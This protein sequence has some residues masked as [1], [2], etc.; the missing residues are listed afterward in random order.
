MSLARP[1]TADFTP[2]SY[3]SAD[4]ANYFATAKPAYPYYTTHNDPMAKNTSNPAGIYNRAG[5][6]YPDVSAVGDNVVIFTGGAPTL[7]G[8]TSAS[9][10]AFA[11]ILTRVNEMRLAAGKKTVGF[12]NPTL[13]ANPGVLHDIT[14]GNNSGC[15]TSGFYASKGWDPITGLGTPNFPAMAKL[16]MSLP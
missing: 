11:A 2:R 13:Y 14:V 10:P 7:I 3:Q 8:G 16:F 4:V 9:S 6:G 12:V 5:R 1:L 15:G